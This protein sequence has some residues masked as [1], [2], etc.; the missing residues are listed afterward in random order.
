MICVEPNC[1]NTVHYTITKR[2]TLHAVE[3]VASKA[4]KASERHDG[5]CTDCG[6]KVSVPAKS[7][8][9]ARCPEHTREWIVARTALA[10]IAETPARLAALRDG[11][12]CERCGDLFWQEHDAAGRVAKYCP[13]CRSDSL[14]KFRCL[15]GCGTFL[16]SKGTCLECKAETEAAALARRD[17]ARAEREAK[18]AERAL[19]MITCVSEHCDATFLRGT[20]S[21]KRR[22]RSCQHEARKAKDRLNDARRKGITSQYAVPDVSG[23][24]T[25]DAV[26]FYCESPDNL[27]LDHVIPLARGGQ[28]TRDNLVAACWSCNCSKQDLTPE[29]WFASGRPLV[30]EHLRV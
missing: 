18:K 4:F 27:T 6:V 23:I 30:P 26:C 14:S 15:N 22:C 1:N 11:I 16:D 21:S 8:P 12:V 2:C 29:E 24:I 13:G 7:R 17:A 20:G 25:E 28:H 9:A 10:R 3:W 19:E 5:V